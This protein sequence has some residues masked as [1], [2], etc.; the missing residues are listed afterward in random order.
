VLLRSSMLLSKGISIGLPIGLP[1]IL[2]RLGEKLA[3]LPGLGI[4]LRLPGSEEQQPKS[5]LQEGTFLAAPKK[6]VSH[7][8][9]RQRQLAGN[10]QIKELKNLNRCPSCG[11]YKRAHTLCMNCVRE[12]QSVWKAR[13]KAQADAERDPSSVYD[14]G[15]LDEVDRRVLYP[16][17][18]ESD[19]DKKLREKHKYLYKRPR[20]LPVMSK[21]TDKKSLPML[22]KRPVQ[23]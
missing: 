14:E 13:D 19:Y 11:H 2:P 5:E 17:K 1:G 6:K 10:N 9:K 22:L 23:R 18:R 12:I 20:T 3:N 8:K 4:R 21:S 7:R 15:D 16:G